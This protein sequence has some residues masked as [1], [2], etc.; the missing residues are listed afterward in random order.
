MLSVSAEFAGVDSVVHGLLLS[1]FTDLLIW[2]EPI[3][4]DFKRWP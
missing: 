3:C 4:A 1:A 2:Q